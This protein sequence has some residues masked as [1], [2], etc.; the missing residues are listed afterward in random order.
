M[1]FF[2]IKPIVKIVK[3]AKCLWKIFCNKFFVLFHYVIRFLSI[4]KDYIVKYRLLLSQAM[5]FAL[6]ISILTIIRDN[7]P[8]TIFESLDFNTYYSQLHRAKIEEQID[9][10]GIE[11]IDVSNW[12]STCEKNGEGGKVVKEIIVRRDS[13]CYLLNIINHANPKFVFLD[14]RFEYG[15]KTPYDSS[16]MGIFKDF[17]NKIIVCEAKRSNPNF[18]EYEVPNSYRPTFFENIYNRDRF[19]L[20]GKPCAALHIFNKTHKDSISFPNL[21]FD[22]TLKN[23]LRIYR[24]CPLFFIPNFDNKEWIGYYDASEI[25]SI[26]DSLASKIIFIGYFSSDLIDSHP[27]YAGK[28]PGTFLTYLQFKALEDNLYLV[29]WSFAFIMFAAYVVFFIIRLHYIDI[30]SFINKSV[31]SKERRRNDED[32]DCQNMETGKDRNYLL[33][34]KKT[35]SFFLTLISS[36]L[37]YTILFGIICVLWIKSNDRIVFSTFVPSLAFGLLECYL[38]KYKKIYNKLSEYENKK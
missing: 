6:I 10:N 21:R 13:L 3:S 16:L 38:S 4:I 2:S 36:F 17:G 22:F 14:I 18:K 19:L 5:V 26:Q 15:I 24:N 23:G 34:H 9:K 32:N 20:D 29:D 11:F 37:G 8:Y 28:Q 25:K 12:I 31:R 7:I 27:T 35:T 33:N 30:Y 1:I